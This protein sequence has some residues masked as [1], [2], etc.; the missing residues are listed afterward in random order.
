MGRGVK[1]DLSFNMKDNGMIQGD[2][3]EE[4]AKVLS[5]AG[6]YSS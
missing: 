2:K 1:L 3:S 5:E 4:V 6:F